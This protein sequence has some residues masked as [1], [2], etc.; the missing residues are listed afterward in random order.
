VANGPAAPRPE[1][2]VID[3]PIAVG[4]VA[5]GLVFLTHA[6]GVLGPLLGV[7]L[8]V[9]GIAGLVRILRSG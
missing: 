4:A 5:L 8:T 7:G 1:P 3:A 6:R 2:S 9:V